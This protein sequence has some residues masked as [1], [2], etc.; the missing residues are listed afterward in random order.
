LVEPANPNTGKVFFNAPNRI[1]YSFEM[2]REEL[3]KLASDIQRALKLAPPN[4]KRSY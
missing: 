3:E 1:C 2:K 4:K